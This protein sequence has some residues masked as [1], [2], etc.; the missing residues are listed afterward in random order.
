VHYYPPRARLQRRLRRLACSITRVIT[1][2]GGLTGRLGGEAGRR[3]GSVDDRA[4][5]ASE[6]ASSCMLPAAAET[7]VVAF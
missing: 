3:A 5:V 2:G 4:G 6:R 7:V 1:R